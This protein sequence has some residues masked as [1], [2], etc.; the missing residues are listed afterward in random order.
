MY[1]WYKFKREYNIYREDIKGEDYIIINNNYYN[2]YYDN[3]KDVYITDYI[4]VEGNLLYKEIN[5]VQGELKFSRREY[6]GSQINK[7]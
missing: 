6:L 7:S 5:E 2:E 1:K 4:D 3:Y